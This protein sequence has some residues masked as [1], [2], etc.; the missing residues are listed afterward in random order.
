MSFL[1]E[2][3]QNI[4]ELIAWC[5]DQF[6]I[7]RKRILGDRMHVLPQ[8]KSMR[9]V[10]AH[11]CICPYTTIVGRYGICDLHSMQISSHYLVSNF[12]AE[13][14]LESLVL[15]AKLDP[16]FLVDGITHLALG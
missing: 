8:L 7:L 4:K 2:I 1:L 10:Q 3:D 5:L 13:N 16:S 15:K 11:W 12:P 14:I 9:M 6:W